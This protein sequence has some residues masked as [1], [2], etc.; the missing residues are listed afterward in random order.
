MARRGLAW[1]VTTALDTVEGDDLAVQDLQLLAGTRP[2]ERAA[3]PGWGTPDPVGDHGYDD[4]QLRGAAALHLPDV[5]LQ[6]VTVERDPTD[7]GVVT[8]TIRG[9][10]R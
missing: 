4:A 6:D 10:A 9:A 5:A 1:P 3:Q 2:G 7:P 8:V